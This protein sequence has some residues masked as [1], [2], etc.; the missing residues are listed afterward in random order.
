MNQIRLQPAFIFFYLHICTISTY[1]PCTP[2][3]SHTER[4]FDDCGYGDVMCKL[5]ET[6]VIRFDQKTKRIKNKSLLVICLLFIEHMDTLQKD[7]SIEWRVLASA[8]FRPFL[9]LV[10]RVQASIS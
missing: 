6:A 4:E 5:I 10:A 1:I 2:E 7:V 9:L 3:E 8:Y